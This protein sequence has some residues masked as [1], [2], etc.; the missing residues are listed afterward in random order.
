MTILFLCAQWLDATSIQLFS[1]ILSILSSINSVPSFRAC[2]VHCGFARIVIWYNF[3][4]FQLFSFIPPILFSIFE[5]QIWNSNSYQFCP[6][7]VRM[8][9]AQ[10]VCAHN[11]LIQLQLLSSIHL[12]SI[13]LVFYQFRLQLVRMLRALWVSAHAR[14]CQ[15]LASATMGSPRPFSVG[16]SFFWFI[17]VSSPYLLDSPIPFWLKF[18]YPTVVVSLRPILCHK[19]IDQWLKGRHTISLCFNAF[20]QNVA[21]SI[22]EFVQ[23]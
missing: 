8:L 10:W 20:G 7:L 16:Y 2:S 6:Q 4:F 18:I 17:N 22:L 11:Y 15:S 23:K 14:S 21:W 1:F 12:H 3:N 9:C 19:K 5:I 13:N